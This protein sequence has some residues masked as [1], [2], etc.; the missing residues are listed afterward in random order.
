ME[1]RYPLI[2]TVIFGNR[3]LSHSNE[4]GGIDLTNTKVGLMNFYCKLILVYNHL[5]LNRIIPNSFS[6]GFRPL[7]DK[8]KQAGLS[9]GVCNGFV[10]ATIN[11]ED[12]WGTMS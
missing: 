6:S 12:T 3:P 9:K 4:R 11:S 5:L 2:H 8:F 10:M 1:S 7:E